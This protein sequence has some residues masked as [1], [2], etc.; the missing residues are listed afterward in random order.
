V[1][2]KGKVYWTISHTSHQRIT[3]IGHFYLAIDVYSIQVERKCMRSMHILYVVVVCTW[4]VAHL[5]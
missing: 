3:D 5:A 4:H 2:E 1:C